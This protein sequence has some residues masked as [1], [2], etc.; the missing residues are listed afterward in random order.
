MD[1]ILTR[2]QYRVDG[3]F[4]ELCDLNNV[5]I[6][7]TLEHAYAWDNLGGFYPKVLPGK[8]ICVRGIH[9]LEG[10]STPFETFEIT[11]VMGHINILFHSGNFND[12]SA[13]CVLLGST[14]S[15]STRGQMI[16]NSKSK[17]NEF[18]RVQTN[19]DSFEVTIL[20]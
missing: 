14:V 8:Y 5:Q 16:T 3:I 11:G 15:P 6:A 9:Q 17:F 20:G 10:M 4:G 7:V 1:M 2:M 13:G 18:M 12:D 19:Q